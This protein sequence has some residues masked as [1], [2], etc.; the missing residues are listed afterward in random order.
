MKQIS[1]TLD[2]K[3]NGLFKNSKLL[4]QDIAHKFTLKVA[5]HIIDFVQIWD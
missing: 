3:S 4:G 5:F 2:I 1:N